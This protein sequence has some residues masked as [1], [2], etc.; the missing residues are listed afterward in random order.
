MNKYWVGFD[1]DGVLVEFPG[2]GEPYG[3]DIQE[4]R[5]KMWH[6]HIDPKQER[7][8]QLIDKIRTA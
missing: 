2:P 6:K 8:Y 1:F 4:L 3:R 5:T 7:L